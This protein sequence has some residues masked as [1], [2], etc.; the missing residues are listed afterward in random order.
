M[1]FHNYCR[2]LGGLALHKAE[3]VT[4]TVV[5]QLTVSLPIVIVPIKKAPHHDSFQLSALRQQ[6]GRQG[7][8]RWA[9]TQVPQVP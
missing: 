8:D 9:N 6:A 1:H 7:G 2:L 5:R 3:G 4:H